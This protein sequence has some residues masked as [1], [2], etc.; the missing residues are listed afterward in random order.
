MLFGILFKTYFKQ[1]RIW[2]SII[3]GLLVSLLFNYLLIYCCCVCHSLTIQS[4]SIRWFLGRLAVCVEP[5]NT[6]K[7]NGICL[8]RKLY[9]ITIF[10][11]LIDKELN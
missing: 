10:Y 7:I 8:N 11:I 5:I 3:A 4:V 6:Q 1:L 2:L 9:D